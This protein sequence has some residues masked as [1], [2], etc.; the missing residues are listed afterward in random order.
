MTLFAKSK[1]EMKIWRIAKY[2]QL[3]FNI[4]PMK[5]GTLIILSF[6]F[7]ACTS[8]EDSENESSFNPDSDTLESRI[9]E[10]DLN[11]VKLSAV[12]FNNELSFIK[13]NVWDQLD[14]IFTVDSAKVVDQF[15]TT[16]FEIEMKLADLDK[17][18]IPEG[19]E[20]LLKSLVDLLTYYSEELSQNMKPLLP[21]LKMPVDQ[22]TKEEAAEL[23]EFDVNFA[24][25][26]KELVLEFAAEQDRFAAA[27]NF[28]MQEL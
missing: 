1:N 3:I 13:Q 14:L 24:G 20:D 5:A 23:N 26:E 17:M 7:F 12:D 22:L 8:G 6:L 16:L 4:K 15:E 19:G 28:Q 21:L 10:Y 9:I 18:Y 11:E 27:N 2:R 25:K